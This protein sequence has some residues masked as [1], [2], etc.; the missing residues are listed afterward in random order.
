[1]ETETKIYKWGGGGFGS[2][3]AT[4]V[5][6]INFSK[7]AACTHKQMLGPRPKI[8]VNDRLIMQRNDQREIKRK[9]EKKREG[10]AR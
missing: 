3:S 5:Y 9:R 2:G 7:Q 8:L 4:L 6:V 1:M 10:R